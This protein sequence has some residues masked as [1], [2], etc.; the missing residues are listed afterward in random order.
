MI[1]V[2]VNPPLNFNGMGGSTVYKEDYPN[3]DSY[4]VNK[5]GSLDITRK[6]VDMQATYAAGTWR[7]VVKK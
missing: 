5:D 3:A 7:R 1:E 6:H 4:V 2:L